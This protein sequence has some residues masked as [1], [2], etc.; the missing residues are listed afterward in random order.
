MPG[1]IKI[2]YI[3][4]LFQLRDPLAL[5][6]TNQGH[7]VWTRGLKREK[8]SVHEKWKIKRSLIIMGLT[9][10]IGSTCFP[11]MLSSAIR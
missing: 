7:A 10:I 6:F 1:T 3:H 11:I 4:G 9:F 5:L 8:C 2:I